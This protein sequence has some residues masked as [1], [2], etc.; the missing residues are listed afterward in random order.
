D[1]HY[2]MSYLAATFAAAGYLVVAPDGIGYGATKGLEHPYLH[3]PSLARTSLDMLRASQEFARQNSIDVES[4]VYIAGWSEGGLFGMAVHKLIED[5]CL[6]EFSVAASSLLAGTYAL[7]A[8]MHL[9]CSYDEDYP[10]AQTNY[11]KLRTMCR[12][13]KLKRTFERTVVPPYAEALASD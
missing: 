12:V 5:T 3:A 8:Q 13:Y 1:D 2:E 10:E 11:W 9:F 7:S 4:R 6:D